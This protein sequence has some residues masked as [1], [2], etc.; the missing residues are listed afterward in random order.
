M[1]QLLLCSTR[2][3]WPMRMLGAGGLALALMACAHSGTHDVKP[4]DTTAYHSGD[5]GDSGAT[6]AQQPSP[7]ASSMAPARE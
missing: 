4:T 7:A 6:A 2:P 5:S 3:I 1:N